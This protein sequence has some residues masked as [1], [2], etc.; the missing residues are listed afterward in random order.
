M[1]AMVGSGAFRLALEMW[2]ENGRKGPVGEYLDLAF[3]KLQEEI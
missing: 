3:E 1:L 2:R